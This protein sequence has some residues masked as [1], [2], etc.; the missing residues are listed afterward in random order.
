MST[1]EE[2][3]IPDK[4]E[5]A[6]RSQENKYN[7]NPAIIVKFNDCQFTK[8]IKT[9][10]IRE[11]FQIHVSQMYSPALAKRHNEVMEVRKNRRRMNQTFRLM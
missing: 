6:N 2:T 9:S 5:R 1:V 10:C 4:I 11:K 3:V 7:K 8:S